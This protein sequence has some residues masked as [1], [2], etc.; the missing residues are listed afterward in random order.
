MKKILIFALLVAFA[1]GVEG[2]VNYARQ[3]ELLSGT[4][5]KEMLYSLLDEWERA[6]PQNTTML[7]AQ[8]NRHANAIVSKTMGVSEELPAGVSNPMALTDSLGNTAGYLYE[9]YITSDSV[10]SVAIDYIDRAI[11]FSPERADLRMGRISAYWIA[12]NNYLDKYISEIESLL[13]DLADKKRRWLYGPTD[14]IS[15]EE[16]VDAVQDYCAQLF[17]LC[18][19]EG[20]AAVESI[21]KR[22]LTLFPKNS[23][24]HSNLGSVASRR[25]ELKLAEKE[26]RKGLRLSPDDTVILRNLAIVCKK[27]SKTADSAKYIARLKEVGNDDDRA[28]AAKFEQQK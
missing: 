4:K 5:N 26:Y 17:S 11:E 27:E 2:Q 10:L 16:I 24:A 19:D 12:G 15:R 13:G 8:F 6:E 18:S 14:T 9:Y 22:V 20:N 25:G 7:V 1:E 3:Y 28:W 23:A 21:S